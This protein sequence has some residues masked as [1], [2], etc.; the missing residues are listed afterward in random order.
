MRGMVP[1]AVLDRRDKIGFATP[2]KEWLKSITPW[3]EKALADAGE[4]PV[5]HADAIR[6]TWQEVMAGRR[7]F[8][9]QVWRWL[10]FIRWAKLFKIE[11][12]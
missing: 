7:P 12:S 4:M 1:D 3:V 8:D 2:E 6:A 9:W 10:N 11:F 5:F